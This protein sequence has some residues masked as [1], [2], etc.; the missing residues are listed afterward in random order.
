MDKPQTSRRGGIGSRIR[1][2]LGT[3]S[4][5]RQVKLLSDQNKSLQQQNQ[6][7]Q[8]LIDQM[9]VQNKAIKKNT[10]IHKSFRS[11]L[12]SVQRKIASLTTKAHAGQQHERSTLT[13]ISQSLFELNRTLY[14]LYRQD[15]FDI[16]RSGRGYF[17]QN[18][19]DGIIGEIA[20]RLGLE[21][22]SFVEIGAGDGREN[23]TI[24]LLLG[25]AS[26]IWV[27]AD[28]DNVARARELCSEWLG[29]GRLQVEQVC[30]TAENIDDVLRAAGAP[31]EV[32]FLS[33]DIDGNDYWVWQALTAVSPKILCLEY[34]PF[35]GPNISWVKSYQ[36]D[37]MWPGKTIY[38][39]A[40]LKAM[41]KLSRE[42]G[43][44]LVACDYGGINAFFV[45]D[46]QLND[47][48]KGPFTAEHLFEPF[49]GPIGRRPPTKAFALGPYENV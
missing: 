21:L 13:Q 35:Y 23:N 31:A 48:F 49:R 12:L 24:Q 5:G 2:F 45:R 3:E 17:S 25:G 10:D 1:R 11:D 30:V 37:F 44:T 38:Y 16:G 19:E 47:A 36:P 18:G 39:G 8:R 32:D 14:A 22:R 42:K 4:L 43:F 26:G 40:S 20:R 41:E 28:A 15:D 7:L 46:D 6:A 27:E 29:S 33:I 9:T 34:N